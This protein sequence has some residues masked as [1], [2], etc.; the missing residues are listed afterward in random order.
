MRKQ[1]YK[2]LVKTAVTDVVHGD[3]SRPTGRGICKHSMALLFVIVE[4]SKN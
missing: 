4:L 2:A 1:R 3:F